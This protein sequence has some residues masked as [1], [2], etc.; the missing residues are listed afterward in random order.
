MRLADRLSPLQ[1]RLLLIAGLLGLWEILGRLGSDLFVSPLST[2]VASGSRIFA[3]PAVLS[4]LG[5]T[6]WELCL[7]FAISLVAGLILGLFVVA[8]GFTYQTFYP[9]VLLV[10]AIPQITILPLFVLYFG[11]GP[12]S[13][14]AF[15]ISHGLFPIAISVI[16]GVQGVRPILLQS[17]RSMGASRWLMFRRIT[18]PWL[19]PSL[20]TGMRLSVTACLLGVLLGE[21]YVSAGGIGHFTRQFSETFQP[22]KLFALISALAL[23]AMAINETMRKVERHMGRWRDEGETRSP[24]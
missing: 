23:M 11:S 2:V 3:D 20:F 24:T 17:A 7:S 4:A 9:I 12:A 15:G 18:L 14:I 22:H 16:S 21:L 1:A 13:K 8:S 6:G 19:V 10:Y 5:T